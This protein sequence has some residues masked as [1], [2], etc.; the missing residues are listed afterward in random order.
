M[1][2]SM[3]RQIMRNDLGPAV[4]EV[5]KA[6]VVEG[7]RPDLH[8]KAVGNLKV[9]WPTLSQ[10]LDRLVQ[11]VMGHYHYETPVE[12]MAQAVLYGTYYDGMN[13]ESVTK[14]EALE[15]AGVLASM[16]LNGELVQTTAL[17][18]AM[19]RIIGDTPIKFWIC[20]D[21]HEPPQDWR[22]LKPTVR[23]DGARATCLVCGKT[24]GKTV[25]GEDE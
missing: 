25:L 17:S 14:D 12:W 1:D 5:V 15:M 16:V 18:E 3:K 21:H 9:D 13:P 11:T 6:V 4:A 23:W 20:P 2:Q 19:L 7:R 8:R 22:A 10:A 24:N